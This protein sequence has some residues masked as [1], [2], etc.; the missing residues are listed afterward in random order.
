MRYCPV[1]H[2]K[3]N[4]KGSLHD[5]I[6]FQDSVKIDNLGRGALYCGKTG[7]GKLSRMSPCWSKVTCRRCLKRV[8]QLNW[9]EIKAALER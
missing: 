5:V 9:D 3:T 8:L 6:H 1:N 4:K 7:W 2:Y